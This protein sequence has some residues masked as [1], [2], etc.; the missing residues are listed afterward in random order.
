MSDR[1]EAEL[2]EA[3]QRC[4]RQCLGQPEPEARVREYCASLVLSESWSQRDADAVKTAALSVIENLR[5][6]LY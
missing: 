2:S 6:V 5:D 3:I 1:S 4:A